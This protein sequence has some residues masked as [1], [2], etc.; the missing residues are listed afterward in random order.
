MLLLWMSTVIYKKKREPWLSS[1]SMK[2]QSMSLTS[3]RN[4][5]LRPR[6]LLLRR[7]VPRRNF[8]NKIIIMI[9]KLRK[10]ILI[11]FPW[12]Y[13]SRKCTFLIFYAKFEEF[14]LSLFFRKISY[15]CKNQCS[16]DWCKFLN[17]LLSFL[18]KDPFQFLSWRPK[19]NIFVRAWVNEFK[20]L[21]KVWW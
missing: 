18:K 11:N 3:R 15:I 6:F 5:W 20:N 10:K 19:T 17:Q 21:H 2:S 1:E 14:P 9:L 16:F 12:S 13:R 4:P 8:S 7:D